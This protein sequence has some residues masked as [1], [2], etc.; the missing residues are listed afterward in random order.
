METQTAI[1]VMYIIRIAGYLG[2]IKLSAGMQQ[3]GNRSA[4]VVVLEEQQL[5]TLKVIIKTKHLLINN[6]Q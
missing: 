6:S 5:V 1:N 2:L 3:A 4:I